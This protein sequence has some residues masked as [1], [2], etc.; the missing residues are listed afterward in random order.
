MRPI[1]D[2]PI[3]RA[4]RRAIGLA[5]VVG[6]VIG[7]ILGFPRYGLLSI[8]TVAFA[9]LGVM[10]ALGV[11]AIVVAVSPSTPADDGVEVERPS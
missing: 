8:G 7:T 2:R 10:V 4:A 9:G 1:H 5:I 11:Y 3:D 6:G